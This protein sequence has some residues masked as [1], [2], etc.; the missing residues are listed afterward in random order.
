VAPQAVKLILKQSI[1]LV[2]F[3]SLVY[4]FL[5]GVPRPG[6]DLPGCTGELASTSGAVKVVGAVSVAPEPQ[7]L[8]VAGG[9]ALLAHE[10]A[11][12]LTFHL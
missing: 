10:L 2:F 9:M 4:Q 1:G 3:C 8:A 7:G 6:L 5:S 11:D 12:V